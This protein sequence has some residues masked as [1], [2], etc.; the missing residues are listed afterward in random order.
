[1]KLESRFLRLPLELVEHHRRV[2]S[3]E[4]LVRPVP[5][6]LGVLHIRDLQPEISET[7][8]KLTC[9]ARPKWKYSMTKLEV[10]RNEGE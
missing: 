5:D 4:A 8:P 10:E 9:P 2:S 3:T 1:M 6:E 7:W